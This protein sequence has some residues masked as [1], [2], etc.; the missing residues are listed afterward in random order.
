MTEKRI[1]KIVEEIKKIIS[2]DYSDYAGFRLQATEEDG[3][4]NCFIVNNE[5]LFSSNFS[6]QIDSAH[7][8]VQIIKELT[9]QSEEEIIEELDANGS[10]YNL[11]QPLYLHFLKLTKKCEE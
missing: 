7:D 5:N 9:A 8:A 2:T 1:A 11:N 4:N 3:F 6:I 10:Y